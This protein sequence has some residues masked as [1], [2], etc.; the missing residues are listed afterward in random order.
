MG[1]RLQE[2]TGELAGELA[3]TFADGIE[4]GN[5]RV[6]GTLVAGAV[7]F[8]GPEGCLQIALANGFGQVTVEA[9]RQTALAVAL[10]GVGRQGEDRYVPF[11][12]RFAQPDRLN[13]FEAVH[14][15]HLHVHENDV[16]LTGVECI[17][18]LAAV[19]CDDH[20]MSD[21]L[22]HVDSHLLV[23][24]MILGQQNPQAIFGSDRPR[25]DQGGTACAL[26]FRRPSRRRHGFHQGIE[27]FGLP[28][29]FGE[30]DGDIE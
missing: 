29:W 25:A 5:H 14:L 24:V 11:A 6:T 17:E 10:H 13:R 12:S 7:T 22:Q 27:Q 8:T 30:A 4:P 21:P 26:V 9:G 19:G 28:H 15:R 3:I 16:E 20:G 1:G 2:R 23:H 18:R